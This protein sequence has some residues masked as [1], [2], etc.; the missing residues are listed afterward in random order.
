MEEIEFATTISLS[1]CPSGDILA[2]SR[3]SSFSNIFCSSA[4]DDVLEAKRINEE[5][6]K[7]IQIIGSKIPIHTIYSQEELAKNIR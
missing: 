4:E 6:D 5:F 7:N 3:A 1:S 2:Y